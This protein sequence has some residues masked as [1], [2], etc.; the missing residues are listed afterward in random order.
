MPVTRSLPVDYVAFMSAFAASA[1]GHYLVREFLYGFSAHGELWA[2]VFFQLN[3]YLLAALA[4]RQY[5]YGEAWRRSLLW[6]SRQDFLQFLYS[7]ALFTMMQFLLELALYLLATTN[8]EFN[9]YMNFANFGIFFLFV[10]V[11][12]V[13]SVVTAGALASHDDDVDTVA[14]TTSALVNPAN[15]APLGGTARRI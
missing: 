4:A 13:Q 10:F 7:L 3:L 14:A 6:R 11:R 5:L 12:K 9:D 8:M 2:I 15:N 1:I